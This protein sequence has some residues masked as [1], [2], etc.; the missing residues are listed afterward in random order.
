MIVG[1]IFEDL[2]VWHWKIVEGK[3]ELV[4]RC[5][6]AQYFILLQCLQFADAVIVAGATATVRVVEELVS[7][8]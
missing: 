5:D 4:I 6:S 2:T 8:M 3:K 1:A 7:R